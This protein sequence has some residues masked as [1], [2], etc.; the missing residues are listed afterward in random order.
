MA[1]RCS[2]LESALARLECDKGYL[3]QVATDSGVPYSTLSKL[4]ARCV[5]NPHVETVQALHDYYDARDRG[6]FSVPGEPAHH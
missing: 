4:T 5:T 3:R 6:E 1:R 2:F